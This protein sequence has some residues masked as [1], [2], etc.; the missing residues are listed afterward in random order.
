MKTEKRFIMYGITLII[1]LVIAVIITMLLKDKKEITYSIIFNT[2]GGSLV[3]TQVV[4]EGDMVKKPN[5]PVKVGYT[6]IGW[7]NLGEIY[8]FS[9]EVKSNLTLIAKWQEIENDIE[10]FVVK[11]ESDSGTTIPNQVIKKGELV[12]KPADPKKDGYTFEGWTL[13]DQV[14]EFTNVV[15]NN[16]ILKAKWK[17]VEQIINKNNSTIK[18]ENNGTSTTVIN[19][20]ETIKVETPTLTDVMGDKYNHNFTISYTGYYLVNEEELAGWELYEKVGDKYNLVGSTSTGLIKVTVDI[21]E[22]KIYVAKAYKLDS[23]GKKI[24][25]DYSNELVI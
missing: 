6:F 18:N 9:S 21:G 19:K 16:I 8:D 7:M 20:E 10:T 25:S 5:D 14:Y 13:N 17:M 3:E 24:Y 23:K 11:F 12:I 22:T 1:V 2:E 4:D 15:E